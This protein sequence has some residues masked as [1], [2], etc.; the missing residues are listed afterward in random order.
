[1]LRRLFSCMLCI[2]VILA[3][4]GC[5]E[6]PSGEPDS[7]R[8]D[9]ASAEESLTGQGVYKIIPLR[10]VNLLPCQ[11]NASGCSWKNRYS[12]VLRQVDVA[13][14][15]Y[16]PAGIQFRLK[17]FEG[18]Y[19]PNFIDLDSSVE[20][21]W[22]IARAQLGQAVPMGANEWLAGHEK[23]AWDWLLA[24]GTAI[25]ARD[26]P[27]EYIVWIKEPWGQNLGMFPEHGRAV[28]LSRHTLY[29]NYT[30]LAHELG[31]AFGLRHTFE[32][33]ANI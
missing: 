19:T 9:V 10:I 14:Q 3:A 32:P 31:H 13:N 20:F 18:Y 1:M 2:L 27:E 26:N 25:A 28:V 29:Y 12:D 15:A 17:S 22:T 4:G 21:S 24:V 33:I 7:N 8:N 6:P 11:P 30:D 5:W 16:F 23:N